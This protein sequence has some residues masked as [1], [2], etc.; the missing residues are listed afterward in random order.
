VTYEVRRYLQRK[1]DEP[2]VVVSK[3]E[4]GGRAGVAG[5]RP[6][7]LIT[8]VNDQPV[9][10]V[11][12]FEKLTAASGELKLSVRRMAKGRIVTVKAVN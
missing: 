1:A 12:E 11:G 2:G 8:H 3:V 7:E 6:Y 4:P 10:N 5:V 9:N